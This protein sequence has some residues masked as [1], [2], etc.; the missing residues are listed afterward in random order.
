MKKIIPILIALALSA[1]SAMSPAEPTP[2]PDPLVLQGQQVFNAKCA[3]CHALVPDTIIIGPSLNGIATRAETRVEG[4]TADEYIQLS[5]LR[6]GDYLVDGFNNVMITNFSKELTN[7][8]MNAL[9][10]F[11]LTLK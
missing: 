10:A 1:C 11:L 4:Q 8:D 6:P 7:E 5:I 9:V 2:T 3:T